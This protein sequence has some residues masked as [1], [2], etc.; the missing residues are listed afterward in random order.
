ML[1]L[2]GFVNS[3]ILDKEQAV[4]AVASCFKGWSPPV[5]VVSKS[6]VIITFKS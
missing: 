1:I 5:H 2:K 6:Q 3:N 4:N